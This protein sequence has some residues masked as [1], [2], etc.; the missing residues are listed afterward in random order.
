MSRSRGKRIKGKCLLMVQH[1]LTE[2]VHPPYQEKR[3]KK[4]EAGLAFRELKILCLRQITVKKISYCL[5]IKAPR[6][7]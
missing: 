4:K 2:T 7:S 1:P 6:G 3:K 5:Y